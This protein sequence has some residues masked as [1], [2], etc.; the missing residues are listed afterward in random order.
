MK[1]SRFSHKCGSASQHR[2]SP[3]AGTISYHLYTHNMV[4]TT[5]EGEPALVVDSGSTCCDIYNY[6]E[7]LSVGFIQ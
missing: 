3:H 7:L 6:F 4:P 2:H 1:V 5:P